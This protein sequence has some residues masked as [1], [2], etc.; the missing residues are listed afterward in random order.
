MVTAD[1]RLMTIAVSRRD[2]ADFRVGRQIGKSAMSVK[3]VI[4]SPRWLPSFARRSRTT[5]FTDTTVDDHIK[6][7]RAPGGRQLRGDH[8]P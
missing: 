3:S 7:L 4:P 2:P 5:D 8:T 1:I 6:A